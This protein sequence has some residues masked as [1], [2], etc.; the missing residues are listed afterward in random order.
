MANDYLAYCLFWN[1]NKMERLSIFVK[2]GRL[3]GQKAGHSHFLFICPFDWL[4]KKAFTR[5]MVAVNWIRPASRAISHRA[6][7][8]LRIF[9]C[10][11]WMFIIKSN[12]ES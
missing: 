10:E 5:V 2:L 9:C 12:N 1:F 4:L 3:R 6:G 8:I 11:K 7:T